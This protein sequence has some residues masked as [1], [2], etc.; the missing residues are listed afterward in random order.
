MASKANNIVNLI[1]TMTKAK[2][3]ELIIEHVN[4][5][6][7]PELDTIVYSERLS[8]EMNAWTYKGLCEFIL[9]N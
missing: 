8:N 1:P 9:N 6:G 5:N 4:N 7:I 2:A 3:L